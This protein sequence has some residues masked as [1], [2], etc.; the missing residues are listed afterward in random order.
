MQLHELRLKK[1]I[2]LRPEAVVFVVVDP[3]FNVFQLPLLGRNVLGSSLDST[4]AEFVGVQLVVSEVP[5]R[6]HEMD[7]NLRG[8][9]VGGKLDY[10]CAAR[11]LG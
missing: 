7:H 9:L 2:D 10:V 4:G 8:F 6:F 1:R 5:F 3:Q 11:P